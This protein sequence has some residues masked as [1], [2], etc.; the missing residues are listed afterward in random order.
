MSHEPKKPNYWNS[1]YNSDAVPDLPSQ[2]CVFM[3]NEFPALRSV[4]EF[5]CGNGRDSLFFARHG[6]SVLGID[7]SEAAI[8]VCEEKATRDALDAR[9][10]NARI[11]SESCFEIVKNG[12]SAIGS[13]ELLIYA[14]FFLHAIDE[15]AE[16]NFLTILSSLLKERSGVVGL[17]FRTQRDSS[18]VK[19]TPDH[20]RRFINVPA[21]AARAS[22]FGLQCK[23]STEGFGMAKYRD[24]DAHVGRLVLAYEN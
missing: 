24:D 17:E 4:I 7:A 14:R 3:A 1:Y 9:F 21:F 2:F 23:Y 13:G 5:G 16:F 11:E 20:Y 10:F 8:Q 19:V 12:L 18:Q 22:E 15:K 6:K